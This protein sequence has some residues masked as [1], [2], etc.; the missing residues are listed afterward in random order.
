MTPTKQDAGTLDEPDPNDADDAVD[1]EIFT[2]SPA[3]YAARARW[4]ERYDDLN[5][6][7]ES[8]WDR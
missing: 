7:P 8:D 3:G 5:G 6:A 1:L 2:E 4:A